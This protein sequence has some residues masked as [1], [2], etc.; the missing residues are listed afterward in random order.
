[1]SG[2][3][4]MMGLH[5][6]AAAVWFGSM[7]AMRFAVRPALQGPVSGLEADRVSTRLE[8]RFR[9]LRWLSL[10]FLLGTGIV[11]LIHEGGS[12]RLESTWGGILMIKLLL[13]GI[14]VM[15]TGLY[16]FVLQSP[17][18]S[19][20]AVENAPARAWLETTILVLGLLI[21]SLAAYLGQVG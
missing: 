14:A 4:F 9:R 10:I 18:K 21:L 11:N 13:V 5:L 15:A 20:S 3:V 17:G 7:A 12:A 1:M 6:L 8:T 19:D 2:A 16:D